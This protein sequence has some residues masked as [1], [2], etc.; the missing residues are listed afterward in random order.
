MGPDDSPACR[1]YS[2]VQTNTWNIRYEATFAAKF[3]VTEVTP[4][5][6]TMTN[7]PDSTRR[8]TP[9]DG[10]GFETRLP[11]GLT[12]LQADRPF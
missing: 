1:L 9:I 11:R 5:T 10:S 2:N 3:V 12:V 4:H 8:A 6:V 7:D